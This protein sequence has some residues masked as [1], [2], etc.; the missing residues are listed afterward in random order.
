MTTAGRKTSPQLKVLGTRPIRHDGFDKVTGRARYGADLSM[1]RMLHGKILRS[2]HAHA[3][4]KSIDTRKAEALPGV[5]AVATA[6]DFPILEDQTIDFA[7]IRGNARMLADNVFARSKVL[8]QGHAVAAVAATSPHIAEEAEGLIEV[9]YEV[10]PTVLSWRDAMK[11]GATLLHEELTTR[12]I[13]AFLDPGGDGHEPSNV[14]FHLH[15]ANGDV[16]SGLEQSDCIVEREFSTQPVHQG[17]IEPQA[18]TAWW[19]PDGQITIWTS[20]QGPFSIRSETAL[21]LGLP[22]SQVNVIPMEIGGGFGGKLDT[23]LDPVAAVLSKKSGSPVKIVMSRKEV[24]EGTGPSS[25]TYLR[26]KIGA[27]RDGRITAAE[28]YQVYEAGAYPGSPVGEGAMTS[29]APYKVDN[30]RVDGYDVVCN[31]QKVAAYRAPG[32]PATAF[33]VESVIDELAAKVEMDPIDFRLKNLSREGDRMPSGARHVHHGGVE[34]LEAMKAHPHYQAPLEGSNRGR[35]IAIGYWF[36]ASMQSSATINVNVDGTISLITGSVD[37]GGTRVAVAMQAAEVL[38][39]GAEDVHP[40]VGDTDSIGWTG[41]TGGSRTAVDTGRAAI[42]AA[43]EVIRQ[44]S[45]RAAL[46][47]EVE[48][49][50]VTFEQGTFIC[51][52][53][54]T[55]HMKFKELAARLPELGGL[56]TASVASSPQKAAP[57]LAGNLADVEVDLETGK[58]TILRFTAFQDVG[59]AAHPSYVEGQMQGGS[60]QGIGWAL[61]EEYV[62]DQ[63]GQMAN[64]SFLDYRMP[65]CLDVPLIETVVIEVP[66][67]SHPFGMRGVGEV[68]IVP[69]MAA[70]ANAIHDATGIRMTRLPMA[71]GAVLEALDGNG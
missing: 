51:A 45:E 40:S 31:K 67:D 48:P 49:E 61:N 43:E 25:A 26:C 30:L 53:D 44:M 15:F 3:R 17:Y 4:I 70:M 62:F 57:A 18:S 14:S 10:L 27:T 5:K 58:V 28:L 36:N 19:S 65:T 35:G 64:A 29:F 6:D 68:S 23:Y 33:A 20:T 55:Q 11:E 41:M 32:A 69:P 46:L 9:E 39:L 34:L 60:V 8:Y 50:E 52:K 59:R 56:V 2:P 13:K 7:E 22:E 42:E 38:G 12:S 21:I 47:W 24:F 66:G 71:P 54:T 1:P 37:I 16:D 63:N